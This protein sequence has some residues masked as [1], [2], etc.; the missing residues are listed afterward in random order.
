MSDF[1]DV[2]EFHRMWHEPTMKPSLPDPR[3]WAERIRLINEEYSELTTAYALGDLEGFADG[4]VDLAWV[5]LGTAVVSGLPF[6][7]LWAEVKEANMAKRGGGLDTSGKLQKPPG[8]KPPD[9]ARILRYKFDNETA[10]EK[11]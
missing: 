7:A 11:V 10:G 8:W 2:L 1:E 3:L 5:I 9:I 4:L 6:D